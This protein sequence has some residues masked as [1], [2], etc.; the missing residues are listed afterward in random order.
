M[1]L[2]FH[3]LPAAAICLCA[4]AGPL[5]HAEMS[6]K[7]TLENPT[8]RTFVIRLVPPHP[9]FAVTVTLQGQDR[10]G[11][12]ADPMAPHAPSR[13]LEMELPP[14]SRAVFE[15]GKLEIS[16][17]VQKAAFTLADAARAG[18]PEAALTYWAYRWEDPE[19]WMQRLAGGVFAPLPVPAGQGFALARIPRTLNS[20]IVSTAAAGARQ[21]EAKESAPPVAGLLPEPSDGVWENMHQH[22]LHQL[23]PDLAALEAKAGAGAPA[24]PP[25]APGLLPEGR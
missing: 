20:V 11:I 1:R 9:A 19:T 24:L 13:S 22:L 14:R 15:S 18:Q 25:G 2:P 6:T 3:F 8:D 5:A 23:R 16:P 21:E 17:N 12:D 10:P 4:A 7:A